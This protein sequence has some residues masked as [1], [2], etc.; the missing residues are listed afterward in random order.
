VEESIRGLLAELKDTRDW[1]DTIF[2]WAC[3]LARTVAER[4]F[5]AVDDELATREDGW[6]SEGKRAHTVVTRFGP[7]RVRRR[8]YQD[9]QGQ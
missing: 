1:E 7:V 4:L 9:G 2:R 6:H 5:T 8:L 3:A